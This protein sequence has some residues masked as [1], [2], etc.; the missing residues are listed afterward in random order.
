[1]SENKKISLRQAE[2]L[3]GRTRGHISRVRRG[4]RRSGALSHE[5][6]ELEQGVSAD[7]CAPRAAALCARTTAVPE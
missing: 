5:L 7:A 6:A 3:T 1:M 4:L 2:R